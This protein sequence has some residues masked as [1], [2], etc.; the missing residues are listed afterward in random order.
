MPLS[1]TKQEVKGREWID[2][3]MIALVMNDPIISVE[4]MSQNYSA[5]HL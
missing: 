4:T 5:Q 1:D 2:P 3:Y